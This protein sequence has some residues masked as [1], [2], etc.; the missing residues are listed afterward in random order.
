MNQIEILLV[1][2][3]PGDIRLTQEAFRDGK[4]CNRLN[5]TRDGVEA[6]NYLYGTGAYTGAVRPDL[7]LLDL[8]LPLMDGREVLATIKADPELRTIPVVILTTSAADRDVHRAYNLHANCYI[9]KPM[10]YDQFIRVV[11][12]IQDFWLTLV[13]LPERG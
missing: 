13:K 8:N 6:L 7:I 10:D 9:T 12:S 1:E 4:L 3:N 2:D 5:V 11:L